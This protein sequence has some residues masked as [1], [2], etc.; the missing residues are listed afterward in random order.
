M[1]SIHRDGD[2]PNWFCCFYDPEGFRR[3]RTT[4]TTNSRIAKTICV[5]IER[6]AVLARTGKLSNEKALKLIRQTCSAI[7]E[8]HGTL[9]ANQAHD[10][11]KASVE[12]FVKIAG[13]ELTSYTVR[14][15]LNGW[16]AD[17]TDA[18]K[19]TIVAYRQ[20]V[21]LFLKH[22]GARADRSLTSLQP[23]QIED[24]KNKLGNR[25]SPG[26]VNKALAILKAGFSRAVTKRQLE[27]SPAEHVEQVEEAQSRRRPFTNAEIAKL[28]AAANSKALNKQLKTKGQEWRTMI[29]VGY[30]TGL[31]LGDCANLTWANVDLLNST[32]TVKT[33]KTG[34]TQ[35]LPIAEPLGSHLHSLAG[36]D[37]AAPL[38]PT[39]HGQPPAWLSNQFHRVMSTAGLVEERTHEGK[40][41]GRS[42]R[43]DLSR[44]S[45]HSLRYNTTSAL[46]SAG[47]SDSVAMEIVGHETEAVS[48]NYTKIDDTAKRA[49]VNKLPDIT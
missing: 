16:L 8:T 43:R 25:V 42:T 47:V 27:F 38:C 39:L 36:D 48:R 12:E 37:P 28:L 13:G 18:S 45:F 6:A 44:I 23:R 30:Y 49:A 3:K 41:R 17:K 1:S 22:L 15:W 26:T 19:A 2:K 31:R 32:L 7:G 21:D 4:G 24:F 20:I 33:K 29:L 10:V 11:L 14:S 46:K 9:A 35:V 34:R 5:N 40:G